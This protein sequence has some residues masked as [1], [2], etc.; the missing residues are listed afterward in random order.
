[1][2]PISFKILVKAVDTSDDKAWWESYTERTEDPWGWAQETI[3]WFNLTCRPGEARRCVIDVEVVSDGPPVKHDYHK[4]N[5]V[6]LRDG[7]F[8]YDEYACE[9]CD[10]V[11]RR[12]TLDGDLSPRNKA[13]KGPCS[14]KRSESVSTGKLKRVDRPIVRR[15]RKVD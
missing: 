13:A 6:T 1:M 11:A 7:E 8:T 3:D 5:L 14:P 15:I 2:D 12:Y 9:Y 10:A 4:T